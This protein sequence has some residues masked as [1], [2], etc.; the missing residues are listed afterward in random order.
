MGRQH[1]RTRRIW[2]AQSGA[3]TKAVSPRTA[4]PGPKSRMDGT[5]RRER[6]ARCGAGHARFHRRRRRR[7][8]RGRRWQPVSR[9]AGGIG[10]LNVGHAAPEL[11]DA[12]REQAGRSPHNCFQVTPNDSYIRVA[13]ELNRRSPD[14]APKKTLLVN[15]GAEAIE[16]RGQDGAGAYRP[17]RS[18]RVRPR[19]SW[20][21]A[22]RDDPHGQELPVL[23]RL[24][25]VG[26]RGLPPP[27]PMRLP[28]PPR[29]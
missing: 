22:A 14:N 20:P 10:C 11:G 9:F 15:S 21:H 28:L 23:G 16:K 7:R 2:T 26:S 6:C 19:L 13:V 5:S 29:E 25:T 17:T 8:S 12:V 4:I 27:I 18:A 3:L 24:W 1:S